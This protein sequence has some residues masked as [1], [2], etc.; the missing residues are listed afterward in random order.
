[1][2]TFH[3]EVDQR[4]VHD[5]AGS[6]EVATVG[7]AFVGIEQPERHD[8]LGTRSPARD[9]A[10]MPAT[11]RTGTGG[12]WHVAGSLFGLDLA[13]ARS[14]LRRLSVDDMPPV[15]SINLNDELTLARTAV[16]LRPQH[17]DEGTR[18]ELVAEYTER[19]ANPY[20]AAERGYVDDVIDPAETRQKVVAGLRMLHSKR[21]ELPKRKH[22]NVPL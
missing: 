16:A 21:E 7:G 15:P 5:V 1:M 18:A 10:W 9:A 20:N 12:P 6:C 4:E 17:F 22:G 11:E 14:A 19:Y 13:L 3:V 2:F 8:V